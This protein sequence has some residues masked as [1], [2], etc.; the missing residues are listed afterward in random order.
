MKDLMGKTFNRLTVI[1]IAPPN[2]KSTHRS[3]LVRCECGK[4][5]SVRGT[6]LT[7]GNTRSCG[8]LQSEQ[9]SKRSVTHGMAGTPEYS[10]WCGLRRVGYP[11]PPSWVDVS[12]FVKDVG[13]RPGPGYRLGRR[14]ATSHHNKSNTVWLAPTTS[15]PTPD[16]SS[17]TLLGVKP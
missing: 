16:A 13:P 3:W 7:N 12:E 10:A 4:V 15:R 2:P 5:L 11:L 1:D 17:A 6:H 8:C 9:T 14:D